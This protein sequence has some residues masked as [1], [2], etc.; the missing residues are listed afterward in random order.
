[1]LGKSNNS[2]SGVIRLVA[3]PPQWELVMWMKVL[4]SLAMLLFVI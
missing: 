3:T 4:G 2:I 1:V